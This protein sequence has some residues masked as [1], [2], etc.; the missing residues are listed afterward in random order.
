MASQAFVDS[1]IK[2]IIQPG[3]D[4]LMESRYFTELRQGKLSTRRLQGWAIQ[5]YIHKLA[6]ASLENEHE[7]AELT[8]LRVFVCL[9]LLVSDCSHCSH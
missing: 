9:S 3:V 1:V 7:D 6:I 2:E 5:H 4:Q 8:Q